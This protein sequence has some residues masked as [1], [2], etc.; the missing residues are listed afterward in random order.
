MV[1]PNKILIVD[2]EKSMVETFYV[3]FDDDRAAVLFRLLKA[4]L[5]F[6]RRA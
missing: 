3:A 5:D 2:D 6:V 4:G 1:N